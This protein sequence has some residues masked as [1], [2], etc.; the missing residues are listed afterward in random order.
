MN[1]LL[2]PLLQWTHALYMLDFPINSNMQRVK[3]GDNKKNICILLTFITF[4]YY[5]LSQTVLEIAFA[6]FVWHKHN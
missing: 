6:A 3:W 4:G 5:S 1:G 2:L